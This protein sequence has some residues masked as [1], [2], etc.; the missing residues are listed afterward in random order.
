MQAHPLL[1]RPPTPLGGQ[2]RRPEIAMRH[3]TFQT[4]ATASALFVLAACPMGQPQVL[5]LS[6]QLAGR[7][8][9]ATV[10][11]QAKVDAPDLAE[12]EWKADFGDDSTE[13][14]TEYVG[15]GWY[16]IDHTYSA[17][18]TFEVRVHG[19]TL[20]GT[21][22]ES[23]QEVVVGEHI[24]DVEVLCMVCPSDGS[25]CVPSSCQGYEFGSR[26]TLKARAKGGIGAL[27]YRWNFGDGSGM[28]DGEVVTHEYKDNGIYAVTVTVGDTLTSVGTAVAEV[29]VSGVMPPRIVLT[30]VSTGGR[31]PYNSSTVMQVWA[32]GLVTIVVNW[33]DG[34][35]SQLG[36]QPAAGEEITIPHT[37]R[38]AG[39]YA[40]T[41]AA[42]DRLGRESTSVLSFTVSQ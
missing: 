29:R 32:D 13:T 19:E 21:V 23:T 24:R 2:D 8:A 12:I 10:T 9:P 1:D 16:T 33:Q 27:R 30:P 11:V 39:S 41:F 3:L 25:A 36:A 15:D 35:S 20:M 14:M 31:A 34:T 7:Y 40:A 6:T 5:E 17:A 18:G 22:A 37:F 28:V 4:L 26:V 42:F 38:T